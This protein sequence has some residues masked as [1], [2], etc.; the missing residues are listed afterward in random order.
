MNLL[1]ITVGI[2]AKS[3]DALGLSKTEKLLLSIASLN[4]LVFG[5]ISLLDITHVTEG[6]ITDQGVRNVYK[7]NSLMSIVTYAAFVYHTL[8]KNFEPEYTYLLPALDLVTNCLSMM[9][10]LA[11][12]RSAG[13]FY[14]QFSPLVTYMRFMI[15]SKLIHSWSVSWYVVLLP[16]IL[17]TPV[18]ILAGT[19]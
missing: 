10:L 19:F 9:F 13:E 14:V 17:S 12:R 3:P 11:S 1:L 7:I 18:Y 16:I 6:T 8:I 5:L 2:L 4:G 15:W